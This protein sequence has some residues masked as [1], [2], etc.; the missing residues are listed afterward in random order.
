MGL[1]ET[2]ET[3]LDGTSIKLLGPDAND[4][5]GGWLGELLGTR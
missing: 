4:G 3:K 5:S 2:M 1:Q